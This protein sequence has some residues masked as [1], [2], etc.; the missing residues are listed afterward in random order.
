M[1]AALNL[2]NNSCMVDL[3]VRML[4]CFLWACEF[5]PFH[6]L[7]SCIKSVVIYFVL[8]N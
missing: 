8:F 7:I 4:G 2:L 6:M 1:A 3:F 5:V